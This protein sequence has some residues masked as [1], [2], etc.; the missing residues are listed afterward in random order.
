MQDIANAL[1]IQRYYYTAG[2]TKNIIKRMEFLK[3]LEQSIRNHENDIMEALRKDLNKAPFEAYATEIGMVL[4][5]I[6]FV[7]KKLKGWAKPRQVKTPITNFPSVS[8]IYSEPYGIVLIMSPWNYPFQ[9]SISPLV[10]AIAAGNCAIVKPSNYSPNTS[11]VIEQIL[12]E[13]FPKEYVT[14][15]Q[16][17]RDANKSLLEQKFDYIFFTGSV[18]VGKTVMRAASEHLTPVTLE[19]G[20]KS[21]CIVDETANL[22]LAARRIVWGKFLNSGQTCVAPD[23]LLVHHNVKEVLLK[24]LKKYIHQFYGD[25]ACTNENFPKIINEKHFDRLLGLLEGEKIVIG[26]TFSRQSNQISPTVIDH[27]TWN[28]PVMSEEIFGPILPVLEFSNLDEV[29]TMVN[30]R[31]KPLALYYFTTKKENEKKI[32]GNIS[33]GGGCINDTIMHLATSHMPFGGVGDSGMGRYHGR[34]SFDTFS[35]K[36]SVLKK[37]NWLDIPLRYPPY[38]DHLKTL[39][40]M[41]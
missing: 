5:E 20:G 36:K 7:T 16:G 13:V 34:D 41:F 35:H 3:N 14:V 23:Y 4:E 29:I 1:E 28:S 33:Y 9:L 11:A 18:T 2:K 32:I 25:E 19:L 27:I 8:R 17:G 12:T 39:K 24:K 22:E 26:G 37:A 21:P 38:K 40:K 15:I 10:G 6:K 30:S 31:P